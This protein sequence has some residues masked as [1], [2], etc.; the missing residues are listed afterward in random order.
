MLGLAPLTH[1]ILDST[2][3]FAQR[4]QPEGRRIARMCAFFIAP[5]LGLSKRSVAAEVDGAA[6]TSVRRS[7]ALEYLRRESATLCTRKPAR[8]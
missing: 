2:I 3:S 8:P 7:A 1:T 6:E 5:G 4:K